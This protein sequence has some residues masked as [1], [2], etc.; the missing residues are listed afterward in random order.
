MY[1]HKLFKSNAE[2]AFHSDQES[3]G[4]KRRTGMASSYEIWRVDWNLKIERRNDG[5]W[6][7][8]GVGLK[9]VDG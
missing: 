1:L 6:K 9:R 3:A 4:D 7:G 8:E 5:C 2:D